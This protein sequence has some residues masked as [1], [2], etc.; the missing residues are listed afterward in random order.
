MAPGPQ[1]HRPRYLCVV[2]VYE[3]VGL[4]HCGNLNGT[5]WK[6]FIPLP[7]ISPT[8]KTLVVSD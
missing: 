2:V 8:R 1:S 6:N 4:L 5:V 7:Y 3:M